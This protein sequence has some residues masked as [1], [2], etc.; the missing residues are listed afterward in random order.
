MKAI[1]SCQELAKVMASE[2]LFAVFDV[3]E[4]GEFNRC[5][6]PQATSLPRSQIEFRI[7]QLVPNRQVPIVLYDEGDAR[8][9]LAA[10]TLLRLGYEQVNI[11]EGGLSAWQVEERS[12]VSGVNVPSKAFGEKIHHEREVPDLTVEELKDLTERSSNLVILDV[13]TPEEYG[14]FCIPGGINVPGGDLILWAHELKQKSN[15]EV[16]VN[17]AGRTRSIIGAATLRRLGLTPV[18]ALRNGTMGWVLAGLELE[19]KPGRSGPSAPDASREQ[20][21]T[22]ALKIANEESIPFT[23]VEQLRAINIGAEAIYLIDVRSESEYES[24]HLAGSINVPGGQAV[25]RADDFVALRNAPIVFISDQSARAIMAAYW[26]R[27]MHFPNISVL[28]GGLR[29]WK[30]SGG[31]VETGTSQ[32]EPLGYEAAKKN[33][34][35]IEANDLNLK[36]RSASA[37]LDVGSS[38]EFEAAH[39]PRAQWISRGWLELELPE[40]FPDREQPI[41]LTCPDGQSS[42]LAA[43]TLQDLGYANV[44]VLNGG[45]RAWLAA[46]LPIE[47]GLYACLVE[48][49]D[50]VLSPSIRGNKE[51]MLRY[52]EWET[53]LPRS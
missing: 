17:C 2:K 30:E 53:K 38:P 21:V 48:P 50:V 19:N 13:R 33:S 47:K 40:Q 23:S 27:L 5:Q 16:I 51:D 15:V 31:K 14:R 37:I 18:R 49:N 25:Q 52:L 8:A 6:I 10:A 3:R 36:I 11:L 28:Q 1:L 26:Y 12:T 29:A 41:I 45:V 35:L 34:R 24:G 46:G 7:A 42:A 44:S 4:R 39:V 20:A 22:Q 9:P 43:Q 32:V